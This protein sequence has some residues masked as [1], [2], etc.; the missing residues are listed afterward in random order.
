[1]HQATCSDCGKPC[2]VPF[3]PT[4]DRPVYCNVCFEKHGPAKTERSDSGRPSF[5]DKRMFEAV[6]DSCGKKCEV[7]FRPTGDKPVY[8]SD[9][10]KKNPGDKTRSSGS[11]KDQFAILNAKLDQILKA[12]MPKV[13]SNSLESKVLK[14]E[15]KPKKITTVKVKPAAK[16]I[17]AKK[18]KK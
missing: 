16:K 13:S 4:G 15:A 17:V 7:P 5:G 9:C 1:M 3:R 14:A 11:D 18:K 12:L 2:E 6:C 8:C 10:F